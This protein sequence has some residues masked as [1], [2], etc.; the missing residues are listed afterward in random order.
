MSNIKLFEDK[1]VRMH[2]DEEYGIWYFSIIDVV[3]MLTNSCGPRVG[4]KQKKK[5]LA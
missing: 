3:E 4:K 1:Q 5:R 2:W